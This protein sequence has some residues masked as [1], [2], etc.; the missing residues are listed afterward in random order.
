MAYKVLR[1]ELSMV[2]LRGQMDCNKTLKK[3]TKHN[4][5]WIKHN[6][7]RKKTPAKAEWNNRNKKK[8]A[9]TFQ[10]KMD[11]FLGTQ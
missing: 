1:I 4:I 10:N 8:N 11:V 5:S 7:S 9:K 3:H 6:G 2:A